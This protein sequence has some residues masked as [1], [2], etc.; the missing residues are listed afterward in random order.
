MEAS[1]SLTILCPWTVAVSISLLVAGS[2][3]WISP[4]QGRVDYLLVMLG[5]LSL[6]V[7]M[8]FLAMFD[9]QDPS[10]IPWALATGQTKES[11]SL[12]IFGSPRC[13][14]C[15]AELG[16][17]RIHWKSI[18]YRFASTTSDPLELVLASRLRFA[19]AHD[20][21]KSFSLFRVDRTMS[22]QVADTSEV[23][24]DSLLE[25][26]ERE[27]CRLDEIAAHQLLIHQVPFIVRCLAGT[28]CRIVD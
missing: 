13:P 25:N 16:R 3:A 17:E 14:A 26:R 2:L 22:E 1:E 15:L 5:A 28:G 6:L 27:S 18:T 23:V 11:D 7:V 19:I 4:A 10:M 21:F 8:P 20:D 24:R 12:V 9:T